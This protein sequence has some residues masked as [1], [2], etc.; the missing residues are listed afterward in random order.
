M[1]GLL[2]REHIFEP[3][4]LADQHTQLIYRECFRSVLV[5]LFWQMLDRQP[6]QGF[7]LSDAV[8]EEVSRYFTP[9]QI[10]QL[11]MVIVT[12]N[13]WNRISVTTQIVPGSYTVAAAA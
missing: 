4:A 7:E 9:V 10:T 13:A 3:E 5:S 12:I 11:L 6:R 2:D 8:Y 1:S